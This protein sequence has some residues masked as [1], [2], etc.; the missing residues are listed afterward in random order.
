MPRTAELTVNVELARLL[1]T[2]HPRWRKKIGVEQSGL[3]KAAPGQQPDILIQHPGELPVVI[4]TEY[5]PAR[6]VEQD[7]TSRLGTVVAANGE[8]IEHAVALRVPVELRGV[9]QASLP[10]RVAEAAF[11][12]C[13]SSEGVEGADR[14][15]ASGWLT[16]GVDDL[17]DF[18]EHTALSER[19]IARAPQILESGGPPGR[20]SP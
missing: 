8:A 20:R 5:R 14:W 7:A 17:A 1:R 13:V 2:K 19:R 16:G 9:N 6:G 15:P 18:I 10:R 4:E 11:E 12:Y 3:L